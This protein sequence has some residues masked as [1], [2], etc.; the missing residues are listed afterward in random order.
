[1]LI[2]AILRLG[3]VTELMQPRPK[4]S[5]SWGS[6]GGIE[7]G[8][9]ERRKGATKTKFRVTTESSRSHSPEYRHRHR[10]VRRRAFCF[11]FLTNI[12]SICASPRRY[13][14]PSLYPSISS[15]FR[16]Q[17]KMTAQSIPVNI[18]HNPFCETA[19][20]FKI[21]Q[22]FPTSSFLDITTN[23]HAPYT[24]TVIQGITRSRYLPL[25]LRQ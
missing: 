15:N 9:E 6:H 19:I 22:L 5:T 21:S 13:V 7:L 10:T 20:H 3:H 4:L 14:C 24:D 18:C 2:P 23:Y 12:F 25:R 8:K 17:N 11:P 16:H 1:M